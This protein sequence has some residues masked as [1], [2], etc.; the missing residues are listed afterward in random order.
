MR[1]KAHGKPVWP[2]VLPLESEQD[3]ETVFMCDKD[4]KE[5][6]EE[7]KQIMQ[8]GFAIGKSV[9]LKRRVTGVHGEDSFNDLLHVYAISSLNAQ[10]L[11]RRVTGVH[12]EDSLNDLLHVYSISSLSV[13]LKLS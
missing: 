12:G 8:L 11:K 2:D 13:Q 1:A 10:H 5:A 9:Q 4:G 6:L 3:G 7:Y